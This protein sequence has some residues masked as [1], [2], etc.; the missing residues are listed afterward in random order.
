MNDSKYKDVISNSI[1]NASTPSETLYSKLSESNK[2]RYK[3]ILL[4]ELY[5]T[6]S[7]FNLLSDIITMKLFN[8]FDENILDKVFHEYNYRT[9][10]I[11]D[12]IIKI[13]NIV[14]RHDGKLAICEVSESIKQNFK[15][16]DIYDYCFRTKNE[17]TSLG[18]F[19]V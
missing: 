2:N 6:A 18:V 8:I 15:N 5:L 4:E 9:K 16:S 13:S 7:N 12:N 14:S 17:L 19:K 3:K 11:I 10:E 1:H